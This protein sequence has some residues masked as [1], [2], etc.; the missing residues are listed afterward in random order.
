M[1]WEESVR[2]QL[3]L[4]AVGVRYAFDAEPNVAT[5]RIISARPL[6]EKLR[7]EGCREW[8]DVPVGAEAQFDASNK[9][10][11]TIGRIRTQLE[12]G[13]FPTTGATKGVCRR[14]D[15]RTF[16]P[17]YAAFLRAG[18]VRS[19]NLPAEEIEE[20]TDRLAEDDDA[21]APPE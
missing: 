4:Y 1:R 5:A 13:D 8:I 19:T 10:A 21:G 15:F 7:A 14:C 9:L 3:Q 6:D 16:C 12:T 2:D 18:G 11:D 17:G 20:E